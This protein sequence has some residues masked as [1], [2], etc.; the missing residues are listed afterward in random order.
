[1]IIHINWYGPYKLE[2]L[3]KINN[4]DCDYGV[5]QVYGTH[6][7]YGSNVLLYIGRAVDQTFCT[8]LSQEEW[9]SNEDSG[10]VQI[11]I[12][13]IAGGSTP[14]DKQWCREIELAEKLLIHTHKPALNSQNIRSI[15][16]LK[17]LDVHVLNWENRRD[18][19]PEVSGSRWT[20]KYDDID[21]YD[22]YGTHE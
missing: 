19:L 4:D 13:R 20:S 1:M 18:L 11:Y 6:P 22:D 5:Y 8:R 12:G 7:I 10:N 9:T 16:D 21:G 15:P 2:G 14:E 17:L 3:D